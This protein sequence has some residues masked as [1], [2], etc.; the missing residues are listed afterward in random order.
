MQKK[1]YLIIYGK[2]ISN[3]IKK[4]SASSADSVGTGTIPRMLGKNNTAY[5]L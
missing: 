3:S 2:K 5:N 1:H 4:A